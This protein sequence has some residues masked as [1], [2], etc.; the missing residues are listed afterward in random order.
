MPHSTFST[1]KVLALGRIISQR[2][3]LP[4]KEQPRI[5]AAF[6]GGKVVLLAAYFNGVN[7]EIFADSVG[8][9]L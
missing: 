4:N 2:L 5:G 9:V 1:G 6:H 3:S 7:F 8:I